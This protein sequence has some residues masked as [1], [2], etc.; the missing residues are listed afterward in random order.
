MFSWVQ[1][2]FIGIF[3]AKYNPMPFIKLFIVINS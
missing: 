3:S 2:K 1:N